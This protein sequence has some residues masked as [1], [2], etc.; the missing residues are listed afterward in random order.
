MDTYRQ[1][2]V[3]ENNIY[4]L[5]LIEEND[6]E[7]LLKVYSDKNALP[8]FNSDNCNGSNFYCAIREDMDNTI[9]YW[10]MEYHETKGFVRFSILDKQRGEVIGT[11]EMFKRYS[12]DFYNQ[13]GVLRLDVRSDYEKTDVLCDIIELF[14]DPFYEWFECSDIVT[15]GALYAVERVKALEKMKFIKSDKPLIGHNQNLAYNDYWIRHKS[16]EDMSEQSIA[17]CGLIC[18]LCNPE[19]KCSCK[20]DNHC[21]KRLSPEGCYQYNCCTMKGIN[22]CWECQESPCGKDMLAKDKTKMR[23]FV[24]CIKEDGINN[25]IEY[26]KRNQQEGVVYHRS[27]IMGDYDLP[28]EEEILALLRKRA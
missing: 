11:I 5:R 3:L 20:S 22:G 7:D 26:I 24:R 13:C 21:G 6:S 28:T 9:K 14:I 27:G 18:N 15:K 2:P 17:Y 19:G 1:C 16:Y 25:F 10:L 4:K 8:F 12:E 23:A